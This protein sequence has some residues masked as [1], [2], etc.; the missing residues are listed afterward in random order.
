MPLKGYYVDANLLVLLIVGSLQ[1]GLIEKHR[2]LREYSIEDY[3]LLIN[4]LDRVP[5]VFVTPNT[6]TETSNLLVYCPD[7]IRAPLL[8]RLRIVICGSEEVTVSSRSVSGVPSFNRLGLTD[9]ALLQV[10]TNETPVVTV[11]LDLYLEVS[12]KDHEAVINFN[13]LRML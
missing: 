12:R 8:D 3:E 5:K 10:A 9:A 11:D 1:S 7:A 6:L 2:R 4:L 13:H